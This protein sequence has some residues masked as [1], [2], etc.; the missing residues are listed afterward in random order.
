M[1][2]Q[3]SLDSQVT[4]IYRLLS[5]NQLESA[6]NLC[7]QLVQQA[8]EHAPGWAAFS[9]L[10]LRC[11]EFEKAGA[12]ARR[13]LELDEQSV[14]FTILFSRCLLHSGEFL[15]ANQFGRKALDL[16]L[17]RADQLNQLGTVFS[18]V[19]EQRAALNLFARASQV[20]PRDTG[21]LHNLAISL[22]IFGLFDR[23]E[24]VFDEVLRLN[25]GDFGALYQRSMTRTQTRENNHVETLKKAVRES[26]KPYTRALAQ[27]A[28]AKELE[29]LGDHAASF[30]HLAAGAAEVDDLIDDH[31]D[32]EIAGIRAMTEIDPATFKAAED[33]PADGPTPIFI[34]GL[35]RS[36]TSLV[37]N[38]LGAHDDVT[39]CG[40]LRDLQVL[41]SRQVG[42]GET[43]EPVVKR[44]A[45]SISDVDF[46]ALGESWLQRVAPRAGGR[47]HLTDKMPQNA[48]YSGLIHAA[49]PQARIILMERHPVD[50]CYAM[51]KHLFSGSSCGYSYDLDKLARYYLAFRDLTEFWK[52]TIPE[53]ALMVCRYE[54]LIESPRE[55]VQRLLA[56]SNLSWQEKCLEFHHGSKPLSPSSASEVNQRIHSRSIGLWKQ[57]RTE[58]APLI[59]RLAESGV[60]IE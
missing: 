45:E 7:E 59:D 5:E 12:A 34:L 24:A 31:T 51:Y 11:G 6:G 8:P 32:A 48:L 35:P 19:G 57:Y 42:S 43:S 2:D 30:E 49:L 33:E 23:A 3:S 55:A 25:P 29:D 50:S 16:G 14:D 26:A 20:A 52:S 46:K 15:A 18:R 38:I 21:I 9:E 40:E 10:W 39:P 22:R 28:L 27:F 56:F 37:E 60:E 17:T 53:P 41:L 36:G 13:A 47:S 54:A 4:E 44:V 1:N 58:L